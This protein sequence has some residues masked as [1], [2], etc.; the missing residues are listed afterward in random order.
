MLLLMHILIPT[1]WLAVIVLGRRVL[2]LWGF[3]SLWGSL[4]GGLGWILP[5]SLFLY[6]GI[7]IKGPESAAARSALFPYLHDMPLL[8]LTCLIL[9]LVFI[10]VLCSGIFSET[11][12]FVPDSA[13]EVETQEPKGSRVTR[14]GA[15]STV[16]PLTRRFF[17][18]W[19]R[20][21]FSA[22][23]FDDLEQAINVRRGGFSDGARRIS[24]EIRATP[25]FVVKD[26]VILADGFYGSGD[27]PVP[28]R[29]EK[30]SGQELCLVLASPSRTPLWLQGL[31]LRVLEVKP[32]TLSTFP[33]E[34]LG[35]DG[36]AQIR[37]YLELEPI[38]GSYK[39]VTQTKSQLG[40][41]VAPDTY[42]LRV[43]SPPGY[44]YRVKPEIE[45]VDTNDPRRDGMFP[46][47]REIELPF[48]AIREY[49][50]YLKNAK[51]LKI[52]Y[53]ANFY[54][55]AEWILSGLDAP[56]YSALILPGGFYLDVPRSAAV[57]HTTL[58]PEQEGEE[59]YALLSP[60]KNSPR[61]FIL[62]D[63]RVLLLHERGLGG[64]PNL[65]EVVEDDVRI[66][67]IE[68][69]YDSLE[70]RLKRQQSL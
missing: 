2:G 8:G 29:L 60:E 17:A 55:I 64:Q 57:P 32:L 51:E 59:L 41:G 11:L 13:V 38:T 22:T 50:E 48:P 36:S 30:L 53:E 54:F 16:K 20:F 4:T 35:G 12:A 66:A 27:S 19:H 67:A 69:A 70:A 10:V 23:G 58:I 26:F 43:F 45:W 6:T 49:T 5:A 24:V 46:L 68:K 39:A 33:M 47:E 56:R 15:A 65:A 1:I 21:C 3:S 14:L 28:S 63:S 62:I 61:Q 9:C 42:N 44:T 52:L 31:S 34:G 7:A 18:G 25:N 37:G 40:M